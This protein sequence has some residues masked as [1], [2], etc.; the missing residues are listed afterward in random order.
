MQ[1]SAGCVRCSKECALSKKFVCGDPVTGVAFGSRSSSRSS[2]K[3]TW[4]R[5]RNGNDYVSDDKT[6]ARIRGTHFGQAHRPRPVK[7]SQ[8]EIQLTPFTDNIDH[9]L[10]CVLLVLLAVQLQTSMTKREAVDDGFEH[11]MKRV[12]TEVIDEASTGKS[13]F[14]CFVFAPTR[15]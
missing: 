9:Q 7:K 4:S 8:S 11:P 12:K 10:P 15:S 13:S 2:K 3:L 1:C 5:P 6:I 14:A